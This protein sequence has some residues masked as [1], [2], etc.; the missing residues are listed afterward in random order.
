[1]V[2]I[3]VLKLWRLKRLGGMIGLD[4]C[5][6]CWKK[7]IKLVMFKI[8]KSICNLWVILG[9]GSVFIINNRKD[10]LISKMIF[11]K[12]LNV[13]GNCLVLG[14]KCIV[15]RKVIIL[16]L[17]WIKKIDC[18]L[19]KLISGFLRISFSVVDFGLFID[20]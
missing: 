13:V 17:V 2:V 3:E 14:M 4:M 6:L 19:S 9:F 5:C 15:S 11:F 16:V 10:K 18:Y 12:W 20:Y 7:I 8:R 1:M